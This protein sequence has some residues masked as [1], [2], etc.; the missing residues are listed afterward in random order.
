MKILKTVAFV[1]IKLNSQRLP[2]KNLLPIA[3]QPLCWHILN[4]LTCTK[5]IDEVYVYCSDDKIKEYIPAK[6]KFLKRDTY[7]DGDLVKGLEI[8]DAFVKDVDADIYILAHATSP[9]IKSQ[10]IELALD[11]ILHDNYDSAFSAQKIQTFAWYKDKPINY[12]LDDIPRTQ[13]IDPIFVET[14]GFFMFKKEVF[15]LHRRRIGFTPYI[16]EV[17]NVEAVDIDTQEDFDFAQLISTNM[18]E[19]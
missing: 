11:K 5:G 7:L 4:T 8:Y 15:A 16:Q 17:D 9:F 6:V 19:R 3:G 13:D 2:N 10:T 14:S 12:S 1:P 18:K